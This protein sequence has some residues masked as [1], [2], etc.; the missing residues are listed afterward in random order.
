[1]TAYD[2]ERTYLFIDGAGGVT[3]A[4]VGPDFWATIEQNPLASRTMVTVSEG[5]GAWPRWEM[6]PAGDEV[7][8]ILEGQPK[9]WFE[10][11]D[12]RLEALTPQ[13][14]A[15]V[16]VPKGVWHRAEGAYKMLFITYGEGTTHKPVTDEDRAR[17]RQA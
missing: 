2:L 9:L 4:P 1:M 16:I 8:L 10:H 3:P 7:L 12:G 11:P 14:G 15:T 6:H 5:Q 13:T 17:T